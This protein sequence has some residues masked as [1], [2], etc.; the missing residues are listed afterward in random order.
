MMMEER[1][2]ELQLALTRMRVEREGLQAQLTVI[3]KGNDK[4]TL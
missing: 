3:E 2:E 1:I 4:S